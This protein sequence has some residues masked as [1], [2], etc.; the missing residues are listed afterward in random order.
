MQGSASKKQTFLTVSQFAL[1]IFGSIVG[2]GI[3]SLPNGVVKEA[4]QDGW[5]STLIGGIYPLYVVIIA[6]YISKNYPNDSILILS[7]KYFGKI[8]GSVF[9]LIFATYF[10]FIASMIASYY[11]NLMRNYIVGFLTPFKILAILFISVIYTVSRG[12]KVVGRIS[13]ISFYYTIFLIMTTIVA[14]R[15]A[16]MV[17]IEPVFGSG[18]SSII[19]GTIKSAFSY[20]GAEIIL[21]IYPFLKEKN[22]ILASSL[23]SVAIVI[24]IYVWCV[25]ITTYYLGPDIVVKNYW[26]L[27]LVMGSVTVTVINNYKYIFMTFWSLIA[28][29][30]ISINGYASIH[31]L[32]DFAGKIEMKKIYFLMYPLL[33]YLAIKFGN[34]IS[35]QSISEH[36]LPYYVIYNLLYM[37]SIALLIFFKGGAKA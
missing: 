32:K 17:N 28:F 6:S 4:H 23:I 12:L 33:V 37:T 2:V 11:T 16:N 31:I 3:L 9:N 21:L 19:N 27:L 36:I 29:K 20:A 13:E 35:R 22:K 18:I 5:I 25:F 10:I 24:V 1:I 15:D 34:E 8:L 26:S 14:L 7:K 30:S